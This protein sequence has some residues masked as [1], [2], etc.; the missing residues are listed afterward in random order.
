[1]LPPEDQVNCS[2]IEEVPLTRPGV[3][4]LNGQV[5]TREYGGEEVKALYDK[6][7]GATCAWWYT[8]T[9]E[10]FTFEKFNGLWLR[11]EASWIPEIEHLVAKAAAQRLYVGGFTPPY[12][13]GGVGSCFN[14][15]LNYWAATSQ[16]VHTMTVQYVRNNT[17]IEQYNDGYPE[18][19]FPR[20]A[21]A[22]RIMD[23]AEQLGYEMLYPQYLDPD[24]N[25]A[26]SNWGNNLDWVRSMIAAKPNPKDLVG[27]DRSQIYYFALP[28]FLVYSVDQFNYWCAQGAVRCS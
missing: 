14:G 20:G 5:A 25:H 19:A 10:D 4:I 7:K 13:P 9:H 23:R 8:E 12:C 11:H 6:M 1:M 3:Y 17:P 22:I 24:A 26:P 2:N 18:G 16:V 15:A 27:P 28:N 21:D